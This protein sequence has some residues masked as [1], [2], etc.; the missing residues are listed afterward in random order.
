MNA[1]WLL[2]S[3]AFV[4]VG[5]QLEPTKINETQKRELVQ[6]VEKAQKPLESTEETVILDARSAFDY[7][8]DR[9][10]NSISFQWENLSE[11][12][13]TGE[14]LRDR[15]QAV[16]RLSL[17]GLTPTTPVIVLG[18]G[19]LGQGEE[20]RLAWTLLYYGFQDVQVS[21]ISAFRHSMTQEPTPPP[22]NVL[23]WTLNPHP[24]MM[25]SPEGLNRLDHAILI[26]VR[27]EK[28][29]LA[30]TANA[31]ANIKV[32]NIE[33]RKFYTAP[34]RPDL[35]FRKELAAVG[36]HPEDQIVVKSDRGVRAAAAAY[37]LLA[38]GFPHV[39]VLMTPAL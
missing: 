7:G 5:C 37:A 18:Y 38:M 26:D 32:L 30:G 25:L 17:I 22:K 14:L 6:V 34:G 33:W 36:V 16:T 3:L 4:V 23:R 2:C 15:N 39:Q 27:S 11:N 8:L 12:S 31:A 24:E 9:V 28:E 13:R 1:R 19:P 21:S 20:G 29:Y 35:H 10:R